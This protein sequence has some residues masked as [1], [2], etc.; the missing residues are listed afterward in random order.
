M[1]FP[2]TV[3]NFKKLSFPQFRIS[4]KT[5][6]ECAIPHLV[7]ALSYIHF[8]SAGMPKLKFISSNKQNS[9]TYIIGEKMDNPYGLFFRISLS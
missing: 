4:S 2:S 6:T 5:F 7:S 3:K 8:A 9:E 1:D